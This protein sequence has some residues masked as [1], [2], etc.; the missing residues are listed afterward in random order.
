M[1]GTFE[2]VFVK[3]DTDESLIQLNSS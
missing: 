2:G 1:E 3:S